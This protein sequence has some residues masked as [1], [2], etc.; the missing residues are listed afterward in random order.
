[1]VFFADTTDGPVAVRCLKQP[2]PDGAERYTALRG[3]LADQHVDSIVPADWIENGINVDG[4]SWPIVVMDQVTGPGLLAFVKK[5]LTDPPR[6]E[7]LAADWREL[8]TAL[9]RAGIA[10]GDLQQDNIMLTDEQQL[11]LVDLDAVWLPTLSQVSPDERGHHNFQHPERI[12]T[13]YW[14]RYIDTFPALV[15]YISLRALAVDAGLFEDFNNEENLIFSDED[16]VRPGQTAL[17]ARLWASPDLGVRD[18]TQILDRCCRTTVQLGVDLDRL[19]SPGGFPDTAPNWAPVPSRASREGWWAQ[20]SVPEPA[21]AEPTEDMAQ[22]W[23]G[24]TDSAAAPPW[25]A[26]TP[27]GRRAARPGKTAARKQAKPS[28]MRQAA[29][30]TAVLLAL[31]ILIVIASGQ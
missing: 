21:A 31:L 30:I 6:L 8:M 23:R 18:L 26:A 4:S 9:S 1:V 12:Q 22:E 15:I 16:F 20:P 25:H 2:L 13:G 10:H 14:G 17:W 5:N 7:R 27:A 19:L 24:R 28:A 3:Y 11:R 29:I